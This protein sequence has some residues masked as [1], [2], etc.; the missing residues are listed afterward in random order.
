[1]ADLMGRRDGLGL[2]TDMDGGLSAEDLPEGIAK[3]ADSHKI[4]EA[5]RE[6]GWSPREVEGFAYRNWAGFFGRT[7]RGAERAK[8]SE[9]ES[10]KL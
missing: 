3:P 7:S 5:L 1:M 6:R 4:L 9:S 10:N 2:G 8:R